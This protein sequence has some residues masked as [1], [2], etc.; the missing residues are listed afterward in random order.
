MTRQAKAPS[1]SRHSATFI[2]SF[3]IQQ[4]AFVQTCTAV[5]VYYQAGQKPL[6]GTATDTGVAARYTGAA[7]Y[8]PTT[9]NPPP[10]PGPDALPTQF[11]MQFSN[12]VPPGASIPQSGAFFG[13]S[14]EMSVVNQV[15]GKNSSFIQVPFLNLMANLQQRSGRINIRVG[16]NTQERATLVENTTDGRIIEKDL[17]GIINPTQTPPLVFTP[18]L[19]QL[20]RNISNLVNVRWYLG[21]PFNDTSNFRLAIAERGQQILGDYLIGLQAGN[22][23]DLYVDHGHRPQGYG[24][25]DYFGEF[26]ML[27]QA[28]AG[29]E[30]LVNRGLLIGPNVNSGPWSPEMVWNTG[31][32]DAYANNLAYLAVEHYPTDN[33]YAQYGVGTPRDPQ[34]TFP[35]YLN[36]TAGQTLIAPYLNSSAYA[37]T[38]GKPLL[39]FETNSASCGGFV[40]ISDS[41][42]AALW[43]LDY[44]MQM[45]YS[46]FSGALFHIGGQNVYYNPFTPEALGP[47]NTTQVLD[48]SANNNNIYSPVY[49]IYEHGNLVRALLFNYVTDSTGAS[50]LNVELNLSGT[51][52]SGEVQV[53]Y[54]LASSVSQKGNFTWAGQTF[55]GMF[56]SDGRP[57]GTESVQTIS[58]TSQS[59]TIHVPAP[60]AALVFLY[61]SSRSDTA[62]APS[63]TFSTSAR[64]NTHNTATVDP[65]VLATSNG[66]SGMD[67]K[68]GS[69]SEGSVSSAETRYELFI[70]SALSLVLSV[71]AGW[72]LILGLT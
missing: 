20:L 50:D 63:Q 66:H 44:G 55:G 19:L 54:L 67:N 32:V 8:N 72:A 47:S 56:D 12:A 59:C 16:G 28:M 27:V 51:Q 36:H 30:H 21:V 60:G 22:E 11:A 31:F 2:V 18:E 26:G 43:G 6:G 71:V 49:G 25:Y 39:M 35:N 65:S 52:V 4:L 3:I 13:F 62:G 68:L 64:T 10:P 7:A 40:G 48:M 17:A 57:I 15:L 9:L 34:E 46:N 29:D 70:G 42:G 38:K 33:C 58:C 14:I 53:K 1:T 24:P 61:P 37:Q 23:P 45:A 41:F 69:T 5:T